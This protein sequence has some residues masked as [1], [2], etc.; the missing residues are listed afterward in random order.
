MIMKNQ[1]ESKDLM[2]NKKKYNIKLNYL[3]QV[4]D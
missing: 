1:K 3:K 4:L 2:M